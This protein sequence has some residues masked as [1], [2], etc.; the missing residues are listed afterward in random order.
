MTFSAAAGRKSTYL[1]RQFGAPFERHDPALGALAIA[2]LGRGEALGY[3]VGDKGADVAA[4]A[5]PGSQKGRAHHVSA[6]VHDQAEG[7]ERDPQLLDL[8]PVAEVAALDLQE[9]LREGE[10]PPSTA[11]RFGAEVRLM[12]PKV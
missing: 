1:R 2:F 9:K 11:T 5:E 4:G 12:V 7:A 3:R 10:A 8:R 6:V